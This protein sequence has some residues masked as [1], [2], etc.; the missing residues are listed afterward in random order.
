LTKTD[1]AAELA[2]LAAQIAAANTAYHT[3]DSPKISD[4]EYDALKRRNAAIEAAFPELK[5]AD[6]PSEQVGAAAAEG[7]GK[8]THAVRMLSLENAFEDSD[9]DEFAD[10]IRKYLNLSGD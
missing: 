10:R 5:R 3:E 6:S 2:D 4:A 9:I 1:A 7:F 8:I